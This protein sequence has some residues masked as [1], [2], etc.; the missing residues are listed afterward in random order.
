MDILSVAI[1][2]LNDFGIDGEL[3]FRRMPASKAVE[4]Q[5]RS[6]ELADKSTREQVD[7]L[8]QVVDSYFV[9]GQIKRDGETVIVEQIGEIDMGVLSAAIGL[10]AGGTNKKK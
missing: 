5:E 3:R 6:A 9:S 2:D 7:Y 4:Y 8:K 10:I 1:L